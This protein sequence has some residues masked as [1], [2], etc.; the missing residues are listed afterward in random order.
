MSHR[1]A[2]ATLLAA[3]GSTIFSAR[4]E[5][6]VEVQVENVRPQQGQLMVAVYG[7]A[8]TFGKT[9][10]R[11]LRLPAGEARMSFKLC[12]LPGD[13]VAVTLF[14]DLDSDGKMG[15]NLLGVPTEP[16]GASG[17]PGT[18]GPSWDSTRVALDGKAIVVKLSQ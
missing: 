5:N 11:Q 1:I 12:D 14:Q 4:A 15:R 8:A 17:T 2:L 10:V 3:L 16:W 13:E 6:C 7:S 9:P 18:F